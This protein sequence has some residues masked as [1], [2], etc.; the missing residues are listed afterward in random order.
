M[1]RHRSQDKKS[2]VL[3]GMMGSGKSSLGKRL[4]ERRGVPFF[5]ADSEIEKAAG[6][7]SIAD[8]FERFGEAS[9]RDSERLVVKRLLDGPRHVLGLGGGAFMDAATREHIAARAVSVWLDVPIEELVVRINRKPG[10]RPLLAGTDIHAKLQELHA[11][12]APLYAKADIRVRLPQ[13]RH[14]EAVDKIIA[15][16]DRARQKA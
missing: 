2:I 8:I 7:M 9:F 14:Q 5:D 3:L 15:A 10:K 4:A 6:G 11:E 12:R 16:L 13:M 1:S